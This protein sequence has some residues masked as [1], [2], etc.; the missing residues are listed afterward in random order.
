MIIFG[1]NQ[2][3]AWN[4]KLGRQDVEDI[5]I[6]FQSKWPTEIYLAWARRNR[7]YGGR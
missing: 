6:W 7:E 5:V 1:R 2:M 3:P 4:G